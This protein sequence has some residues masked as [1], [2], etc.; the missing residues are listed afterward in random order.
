[1]RTDL[2]LREA[3][4]RELGWDARVRETDVDVPKSPCRPMSPA[5]STGRFVR[6]RTNST[7]AHAW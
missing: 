2:Q 7:I 6:P 5:P 1:M 4:L 3:V